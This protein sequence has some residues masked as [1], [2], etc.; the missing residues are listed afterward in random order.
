ML[1]ATSRGGPGNPVLRL[2]LVNGIGG[3]AIALALVAAILL[4]DIGHL[5]TLVAGYD[6]PIVPLALL[7]GGFVITFSSV[8]MGSAIMRLGHSEDDVGGGGRRVA[9]PV[10]AIAPRRR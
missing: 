7:V 4:L 5:G 8:A 2:L 3:A 10:P 1:K 9:V 6:V